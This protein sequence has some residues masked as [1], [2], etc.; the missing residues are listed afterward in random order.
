MAI[1]EKSFQPQDYQKYVQRG[2]DSY[3]N[4]EKMSQDVTKLFTDEATRRENVKADIDERTQ[5]LYDQ[6]AEVEVNK[7]GKWSDEVYHLLIK[8][9]KL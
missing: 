2:P 9:V 6:L 3:V 4:W 7:D 1:Q 5:S 8:F